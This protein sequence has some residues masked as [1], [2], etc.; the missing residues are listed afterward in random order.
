MAGTALKNLH[1]FESLC[2]KDFDNIVL[3]T[4]M[5]DEV[6]GYVGYD[7]EKELRR[8]Y[9][10]PM[11]DRGSS[12]RR[13]LRTRQSALDVLE[14]IILKLNK[15]RVLLL[16]RE[17]EDLGMRLNQTSAGQTLSMQL[18]GVVVI[19]EEKLNRIRSELKGPVTP[20]ELNLLMADYQEISIQIQNTMNDA[21]RMK[22]LT[23]SRQPGKIKQMFG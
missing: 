20:Q 17:V 3:T 10:Q 8:S 14:P 5:W 21:K 23:T 11:V 13:F 12:V 6:E 2:G 22:T 18:E 1:L 15:R 7:R 4:T 16:Q 19:Q 9:W